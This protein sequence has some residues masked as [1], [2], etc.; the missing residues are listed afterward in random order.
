MSDK[1]VSALS[2]A[3]FD[4]DLI[5]T[6]LLLAT[7]EFL[8]GVM[9]AWQGDTFGR[10]TYAAMAKAMPENVWA[11]VFLLTSA[12]Q[13]TIVL[14]GDMHS[15]FARYFAAYNA[16]LWAFVVIGMLISVYPPPAAVA[17]EITLSIAAGWV[18]FRPYKLREF[19]LKGRQHVRESQF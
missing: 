11:A 6:R 16:L 19:I 15:A 17:G 3:L 13:L 2:R 14:R 1:I 9:L 7:A 4:T 10:P 18:F 5:M 12:A 8:W